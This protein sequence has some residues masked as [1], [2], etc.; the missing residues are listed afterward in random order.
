MRITDN[1][2]YGDYIKDRLDEYS[3]HISSYIY[4]GLV[5]TALGMY[6]YN[7][8][9]VMMLEFFTTVAMGLTITILLTEGL[10]A[11]MFK[12]FKRNKFIT[13]TFLFV[14]LATVILIWFDL[15][16]I[17]WSLAAGLIFLIPLLILSV[18]R[19]RLRKNV[20]GTRS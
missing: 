16:T 11:L 3:R 6:W 20:A 9:I 17:Y 12:E 13:Y 7:Y 5:V 8:G 19:E 10:T 14:I 2:N 4:A 18:R 15:R 1:S